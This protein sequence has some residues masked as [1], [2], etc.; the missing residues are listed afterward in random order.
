[1]RN[2]I[3]MVIVKYFWLM[4]LKMSGLFSLN[5]NDQTFPI[6]TSWL[7]QPHTIFAR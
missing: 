7:F 4:F 6:Y 1:M 5:H 2:L 3:L